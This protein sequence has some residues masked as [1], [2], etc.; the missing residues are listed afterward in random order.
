MP[1]KVTANNIAN[2]NTDWFKPTRAVINEEANGSVK[3]TLSQIQDAGVDIAKEM[4]VL[5]IEKV[6]VQVN[7]KSCQTEDGILKS[8]IDIKV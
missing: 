6:R 7:V 8:L 5:M 2:M 3:L 4:V 1:L